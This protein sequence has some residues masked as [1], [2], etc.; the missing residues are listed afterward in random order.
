MS[1]LTTTHELKVW[2]EPFVAVWLNRKTFELRHDD[3]GFKLGDTLVLREWD[4]LSGEYTG[5]SVTASVTYLM[6]GGQVEPWTQAL[7][8]GWVIMD[9]L[10]SCREDE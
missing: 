9:F 4:P 2:P 8:P 1:A 6:R 3:R 7:K 10:E 5:R